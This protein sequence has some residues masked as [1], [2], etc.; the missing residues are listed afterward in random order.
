GPTFAY[1]RDSHN[2][3]VG[4]REIVKDKVDEIVCVNTCE[5]LLIETNCGLFAMTGM[6]NFCGRKYNLNLIADLERLG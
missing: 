1:L 2:S 4:M 5:D 3:V 6:S